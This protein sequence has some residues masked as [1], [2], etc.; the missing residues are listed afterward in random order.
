[1]NNKDGL[2]KEVSWAQ[3]MAGQ[4]LRS[5]IVNNPFQKLEVVQGNCSRECWEEELRDEAG[6]NSWRNKILEEDVNQ[7]K[8][9]KL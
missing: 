6:V 5:R 2:R 8:E 1:M 9:I 3:E 7:V 4:S